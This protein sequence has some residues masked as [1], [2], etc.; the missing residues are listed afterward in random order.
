MPDSNPSPDLRFVEALTRYQP[1]LS[2][3]CHANLADRNAAAEVLQ[4]TN[5]KL[6]KKSGDWDP[7][8]EFLPWA[9]AVARFTILSHFRDKSRD[10]LVFDPDVVESLADDAERVATEL[11]ERREALGVCLGKLGA[12]QRALLHAHYVD[13]RP[14]REIARTTR[15][16][17]SAVKMNM[18][19]LRQ[20]LSD[21]IQRELGRAEA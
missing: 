12:E 1:V 10:R 4:E 17:D 19:R 16:S 15:R 8:T 18:L 14:L 2:A 3:F 7:E 6:W 21:C 9:F 20:V 13:G 11:P 5:L